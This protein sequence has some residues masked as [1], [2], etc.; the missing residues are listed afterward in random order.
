MREP[1]HHSAVRCLLS[2]GSPS[3]E[4]DTPCQCRLSL[5]S[6]AFT[7][8]FFACGI[9]SCKAFGTL[10]ALAVPATAPAFAPLQGVELQQ[11]IALVG[12]TAAATALTAWQ[13]RGKAGTMF[14]RL[15]SLASGALFALGLAFSG[16]TRPSIVAACLGLVNFQLMFVMAGA[17][18]V[19][20]PVF[21]LLIA[22][23][24]TALDGTALCLPATRSL[25]RKL[26]IGG[27]LFGTGWGLSGLCPGPALVALAQPQQQTVAF[28][29]AMIAAIGAVEIF[30]SRDGVTTSAKAA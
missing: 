11:A 9:A 27:V 4:V 8:V 16:M 29:A 7:A 3:N 1:L 14:A 23:R 18:A 25:D 13:A 21:Q 12:T 26:L 28:V 5:R 22:K 24:D 30:E 20:L 2:Q 17:L 15:Y 10:D 19:S 6:L